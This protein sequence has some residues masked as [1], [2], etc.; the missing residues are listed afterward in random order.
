[1]TLVNKTLR[2]RLLSEFEHIMNFWIDKS[3]DEKEGGFYGEVNREGVPVANAPKSVVLNA[4]ILWTF[5]MA[6]NFLKKEEYL[7]MAHRAYDYI[8]THCWDTQQGGLFWSV[9]HDGKML[10]GRKQIYAQGFGIYGLSEYYVASGK[11]ESLDYALELYHLIEKH[12]FDKEHKGYIEAL[13][14]QWQPLENMRLSAKDANEPKSMNTHLHIIE[15]YTN[16]YRVWP[17]KT[18]AQQMHSLISVFLDH[19]INQ[20]TGHFKLFFEMDWKVKGNMISYG[21]DIEGAWLLCEAAKV[22]GDA[23]LI[24]EV[25]TVALKMT[26]AIIHEA[27][28]PDGSLYYE[29]EPDSGHL[30]KDRH[31][32]PQTE[33]L[34]GF[35]NAW[36]ITG[37]DLYLRKMEAIWQFIDHKIIDR[38]H[39]EWFLR[40]NEQNQPVLSDPKIGFWKC[41][42]HNSRALMEVYRRIKNHR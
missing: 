12:S 42:Y 1:M 39:G 32:W 7:Q 35:M 8:I 3:V 13:S 9:T 20:K 26:D 22:L 40:I 23:S 15:P 29:L 2:P 10:D 11:Q 28:A 21:H 4:R 41:P 25:Q 36:Q 37:N 14:R 24:K 30:E 17:D 33:A 16:L 5:S 19:I 38:Q 18:L 6:Y 34:V 31:W 27:L